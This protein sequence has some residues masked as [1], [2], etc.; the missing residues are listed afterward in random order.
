MTKL[1]IFSNPNNPTG[2]GFKISHIKKILEAFKDKTVLVDEA[3]WILWWKCN[4][5]YKW[6][7]EF[8]CNKNFIKGMGTS[9]LRVGF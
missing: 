5:T 6:I 8:N 2:Y 9:T 4:W 1:I 3:L 7:Q